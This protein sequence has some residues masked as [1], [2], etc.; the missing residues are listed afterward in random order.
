MK[1]LLW[2]TVCFIPTLAQAQSFTLLNLTYE[3]H[4][5]NE[6]LIPSE[7]NKCLLHYLSET[8]VPKDWKINVPQSPNCLKSGY[9]QVE[10]LDEQK[11]IKDKLSGFFIDGFFVGNTPLNTSVVKR[12]T[13]AAGKQEL[14]YK[15][16]EDKDLKINYI[17][18]A[19]AEPTGGK[20]PAF[21]ACT[22]FSIVLLTDR[23]ELLS[24]PQTKE[25]IFTVVKSYAQIICPKV[26][27]IQIKAT[28]DPSLTGRFYLQETLQRKG[29]DWEIQPPKEENVSK[30]PDA[31]KMSNA[32]K[33]LN[34]STAKGVT[35]FFAIRISAHAN[36]DFSFADL[37][38]PIKVDKNLTTGWWL[39]DGSLQEMDDFEKK[40]SGI[41]LHEKAGVL[42]GRK[43]IPCAA[44][45]CTNYP[46]K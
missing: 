44:E 21:D 23:K 10:I 28:D 27:T 41:G 38:Y 22:P 25:N 19:T 6:Y 43:A 46:A 9:H 30:Q 32:P 15:I 34:R 8:P 14:F 31:P 13:P 42:T 45:G 17:G 24:R 4:P 39:V 11:Q 18:K 3:G 20:Y 33:M 1:K 26:K 16:E 29:S 2:L 36:K 5:L 12:Y 40:K 7:D 37:P 35:P